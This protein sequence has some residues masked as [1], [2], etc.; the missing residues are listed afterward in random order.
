M[1]LDYGIMILANTD[2]PSSACARM[3]FFVPPENAKG[4]KMDPG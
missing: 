2:E 3:K 1:T 4:I